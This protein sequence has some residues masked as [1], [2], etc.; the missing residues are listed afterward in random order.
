MKTIRCPYCH[1]YI[2]STA[3][4]AHE[5]EHLMPRADGQQT[6]YMTLAPEERVEGSLNGIPKVYEHNKCGGLTGMPEE[7]IRSYL[8]NP[9]LYMADRSFCCTCGKHVPC[10]ECVWIETGED[11]QSYTNK[12]RAQKPEFRPG[13]LIRI[14][15]G[16]VNVFHFWLDK[17]LHM[18]R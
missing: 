14:R 10:R 11:L 16:I 15:I 13:L 8:K 4:P 3:Y 7:I 17:I 1:E 2:G 18:T 9:Y 6:E 12:L 5:A